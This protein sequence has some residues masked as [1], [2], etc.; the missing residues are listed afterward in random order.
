MEISI[1]PLETITV[2][3]LEGEITTKTAP[4]IEAQILPLVN[5]G[6]K[7]LLDM[8]RVG[9]MSSAGL[10]FLLSLYRQTAAQDSQLVLVGLSEEIADTM[11]VTGFLHFFTT[12]D[13][14]ES[15]LTLLR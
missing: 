14:L 2:V 1:S 13:T 9:Y 11:M 15:G 12:C 10:R 7:L 6:Q 4:S 8:S 5:S 3:S